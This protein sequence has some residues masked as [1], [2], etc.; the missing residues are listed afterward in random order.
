MSRQAIGFGE[1]DVVYG[2][3]VYTWTMRPGARSWWK[4]RMRRRERRQGRQEAL[5]Q[6]FLV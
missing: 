5:A 4:R 6:A 2:K 3:G 1:C